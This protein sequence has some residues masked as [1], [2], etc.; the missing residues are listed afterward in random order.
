[1]YSSGHS[2]RCGTATGASNYSNH[3]SPVHSMQGSP[4]NIPTTQSLDTTQ[5]RRP[6]PSQPP[7]LTTRRTFPPALPPRRILQGGFNNIPLKPRPLQYTPQVT[8]YH[9]SSPS[10]PRP[11]IFPGS[12]DLSRPLWPPRPA[13]SS[14][15]L[16][17]L[18][19]APAAAPRQASRSRPST[20]S[21]NV[22]S[23]STP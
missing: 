16:T 14:G 15:S 2:S 4:H 8:A 22:S 18:A 3:A 13:R 6:F 9:P 19:S 21:T 12:P 10:H 20:P 5:E 11:P 1:M 7:M 23:A 17:P